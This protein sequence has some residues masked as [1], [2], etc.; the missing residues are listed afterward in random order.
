MLCKMQAETTF[1]SRGRHHEET[2]LI[3]KRVALL[4]RSRKFHVEST[5]AVFIIENQTSAFLVCFAL[6]GFMAYQPLLV[7][8]RQIHFYVNNQ[9]NL[10]QF[11]LA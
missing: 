5:L 3:I 1:F 6:L 7:N 10:K 11:G 9:F 8:Y 4:K 2:W